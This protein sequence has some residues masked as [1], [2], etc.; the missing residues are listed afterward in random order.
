MFHLT[1]R[2]IFYVQLDVSILEGML[3][4]KMFRLCLC[5]KLDWDS[6]IFCIAFSVLDPRFVIIRSSMLCCCNVWTGAP[7]YWDKLQEQV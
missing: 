2:I 6:Y 4:F 5:S 7:S 3:S 1:G